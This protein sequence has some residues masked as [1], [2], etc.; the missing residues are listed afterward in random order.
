VA[1]YKTDLCSAMTDLLSSFGA[2][3]INEEMDQAQFKKEEE[4]ERA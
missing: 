4:L 3:D 2:L 1:L